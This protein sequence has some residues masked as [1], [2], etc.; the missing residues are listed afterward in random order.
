MNLKNRPRA[1]TPGFWAGLGD[2]LTVLLETGTRTIK[3]AARREAGWA[4]GNMRGLGWR[5]LVSGHF[6]TF[7]MPSHISAGPS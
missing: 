3:E 7:P 6:G 1:R 2:F 5:G 4:K